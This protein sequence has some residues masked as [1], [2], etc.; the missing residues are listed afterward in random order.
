[1]LTFLFWNLGRNQ[2]ASTLKRL[3]ARHEVD[4]LVVAECQV[5]IPLL[6]ESLNEGEGR[7]LHATESQCEKIQI[8]TGF[9]RDLISPVNESRRYTIRRL[10]LPARPEILLVAAH[11]PDKRSMSDQSLIYE[12]VTLAEQIDV[13]EQRAGHCRTILMGDLNMN[14]FETGIVGTR[15]LHAVMDRSVASRGSRTVQRRRYK[16]FY[17][18]MWGHLG[19]VTGRSSGTY[20][21]DRGE[22]VTYFWNIFDQVL[23]RPEL[24][25]SFESSGL[26][27]LVGD[28]TDS[29]LSPN[30]RPKGGA[31]SD[32]LPILFKLNL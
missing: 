22:H 3:V 27:I 5:G 2:L 17:N 18:P 12:C 21:Y 11:L 16:F 4:I 14:P 24:L 20:Y 6:L 7:K 32:H 9:A 30:G 29:F 19:D 10:T 1:M 26:E 28:G 31:F 15:G 8:Y 23:V 25:A 13:E